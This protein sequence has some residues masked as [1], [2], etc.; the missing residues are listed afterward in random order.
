MKLEKTEHAKENTSR[1]EKIMTPAV[2]AD[3]LLGAVND[4]APLHDA[5]GVFNGS[6]IDQG[7]D[8]GCLEA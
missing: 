1:M 3:G 4:I 7:L 5:P 6:V 2:D 8:A